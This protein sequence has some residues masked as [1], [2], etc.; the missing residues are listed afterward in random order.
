MAE[1]ED[2]LGGG[3]LGEGGPPSAPRP[4]LTRVRAASSNRDGAAS[5]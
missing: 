2:E 4:V 5:D 1:R 3:E